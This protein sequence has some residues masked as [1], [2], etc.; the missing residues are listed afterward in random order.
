MVIVK[1]TEA[2]TFCAKFQISPAAKLARIAK[3]M[4][5]VL[6]ISK[7]HNSNV[8]LKKLLLVEWNKKKW[9]YHSLHVEWWKEDERIQNFKYT[10]YDQR[11]QHV[12]RDQL[13]NSERYEID[14]IRK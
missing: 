7:E 2:E 4:L 6:V 3:K 9:R 5:W 11:S 12:T 10:T 13:F 8:L 1:K 14:E